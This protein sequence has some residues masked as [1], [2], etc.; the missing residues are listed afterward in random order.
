ILETLKG[1]PPGD[2]KLQILN[3]GLGVPGDLSLVWCNESVSQAG[4]GRSAGWC[5]PCQVHFPEDA[6]GL[7]RPNNPTGKVLMMPVRD[8]IGGTRRRID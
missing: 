8:R 6:P 3:L 5:R 4:S 7:M 2:Y 1:Q